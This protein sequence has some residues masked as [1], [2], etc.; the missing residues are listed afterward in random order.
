M[1][2]EK[3]KNFV[4]ASFFVLSSMGVNAQVGTWSGNLKVQGITLPLVFHFDNDA[5]T[6]D[7]PSQG[8]KG[9]KAEK[10]TSDGKVRIGVPQIGAMFEGSLVGDSIKGTFTQSGMSLPLTLVKGEQKANRPQTPQPPF[11]Y[12]TE[13]V[14]FSNDGFTFN[15]TL[16][17]PSNCTSQT[18]VVLLVTGS[19]QQNRDEEI[20]EHKPFAV[21]A[22]F[23]ARRGI[24]SLRY[25][26]RGYGDKTVRFDSFTTN[27]FK[28]DATAALALLRNRFGKV[29]IIGHSEG[30]TI[31]MMLAA[32]GKADFIVS[33]AGMAVS[34]AETLIAQNRSALSSMGLPTETVDSYCNAL[35]KALPQIAE[36]KKV[37]EI[38]TVGVPTALQ[39]LW[40]KAL[41]QS[42]SP[43]MRCFITLD[44]RPLLAS[45]HCP[46]LALNGT[47]DT[48]VDCE[49]NLGALE[50]GLTASKKTIRAFEGLNH[51]FQTCTTGNVTEYAQITETVSPSVLEVISTWILGL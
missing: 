39:P 8:V 10:E 37:N 35:K 46:V 47:K 44:P 2:M 6:V 45:V 30:G 36:G 28:S 13:E 18:P 23:L 19:G 22:D 43:Y 14:T 32:E 5:C 42:A 1:C 15:G 50:K 27:D 9:L 24:A 12:S 7:S 29:G 40:S 31:A 25:D 3:I 34:G 11:P 26:D 33:M 21:I 41:G 49:I 48:Q 4:L 16:T 38:G 17:L 51:L 20:F